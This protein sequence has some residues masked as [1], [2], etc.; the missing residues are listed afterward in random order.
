MVPLAARPAPTSIPATLRCPQLRAAAPR[1]TAMHGTPSCA[2]SAQERTG[3]ITNS[4]IHAVVPLAARQ[5]P[6]SVPATLSFCQLPSAARSGA[7]K[8]SHVMVP[9]AARQAPK[10]VPA[11]LRCPQLRTAAPRRTAM[12]WYPYRLHC[13]ALS[14]AQRRPEAQP[15]YGTPSCATSAQERTGYIAL[16][17]AAHSGAQ[18][19]SHVMVPLA[20][21]QAPKS[22]PVTFALPSAAQ[23]S[24]TPSCATSAQERTGYIALPS[25]AHSGAQ[26]HSHVMVPLAARQAPKSVPA[27]LRCPQLRTAAP[28]STAMLWYP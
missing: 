5:A 2:T 3:H 19:H 27:T 18:K 14:C 22:V 13:A 12:L 23:L 9:L 20:A 26:K 4:N 24:G 8:H 15:C 1:S 6:K 17:S 11:T 21:R 7:Q 25:A 16:P 10:S 28:R